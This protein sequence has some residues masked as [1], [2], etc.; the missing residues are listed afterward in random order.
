MSAQVSAVRKGGKLVVTVSEVLS[1]TILERLRLQDGVLRA[2]VDDWRAMVDCVL[3][4]AQHDGQVFNVTLADMPERKQDLVS[5]CYELDPPP[6]GASIAVKII[7]M[8]GEELVV[9]FSP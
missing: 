2:E 6:A 5:G 7:D 3:I 8:L 9:L 4:D 1:P